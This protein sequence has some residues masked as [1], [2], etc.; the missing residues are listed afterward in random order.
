[1]ELFTLS[2]PSRDENRSLIAALKAAT[3]IL[4]FLAFLDVSNIGHLWNG[5]RS[6]LETVKYMHLRH[7]LVGSAMLC[8]MQN[9]PRAVHIAT[10]GSCYEIRSCGYSSLPRPHGM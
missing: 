1:M 4:S 7:L 6:I 3:S 8:R 10:N 2:S 5:A 9:D